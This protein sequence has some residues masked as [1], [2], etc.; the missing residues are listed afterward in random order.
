MHGLMGDRLLKRFLKG[1][2][3][4]S[5]IASANETEPKLESK[6]ETTDRSHG[7]ENDPFQRKEEEE[8]TKKTNNLKDGLDMTSGATQSL[9]DLQKTK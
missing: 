4:K 7:L 6:A 3:C 8:H 1:I 2:R 9:D 5:K